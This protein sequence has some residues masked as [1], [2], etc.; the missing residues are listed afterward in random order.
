L[1]GAL[2]PTAAPSREETNPSVPDG[3]LRPVRFLHPDHDQ[4]LELSTDDVFLTP[5]YFDGGSRLEVDLTPPDFSGCSHP[6]VSANMN[7]V[8]GK[9]MAETMARFGGLGVLPQDMALDTVDRIVKHIRAADPRYDTPLEVSPRETLR[10]VQGI[11]RK[12][13]HDLVVVVDEERRP[14]GIVT[15]SILR[16]RDQYTPVSSLM[17]RRLVSLRVGVKNRD[18]FVEME[19]ARVKAAPVLDDAGRLVGVLTRDDA[20]RLELLRPALGANGELMV[21]AAVGISE[22]APETAGALL[23]MGICALVLDTAHGHQRRMLET[24]RAVKKIVSG[25][26]P[27]V[28]GNV[29]TAEGTRALIEAGADVVKVNVGPGAMCTTRMQTGAGRPTFTSVLVC[30]RE[31]RAL[32][33]HVWADGGVRHPRDVALYLAAGAA[34]VMVGTALAG[35]YESPGDVKEDKD[36]LLYKENYGM[37]SGRAVSDRTADRDPFESAKKGFFREGISTSRIYIR[38]GQESV[39]AI[40]IDMITGVQSAFTYAGAR[41]I[42][43]LSERAV[44]GVQTAA[45]Y[46]EGTPH[47]TIRR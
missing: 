27:I 12:R 30:A 19:E 25:R 9:R 3:N 7:A 44:I 37:A 18:A 34:R 21:A 8:T 40:L 24:I 46:G 31:A 13:S 38:E 29:C 2:P 42:D 36:G 26:V 43:E 5:G 39:G 47:G 22:R 20:V 10:D 4:H 32:G 17:S 11:I 35:T 23:E 14:L 15:H 28:A 41:T 33:K 45:G 6:I 1:K 16:D